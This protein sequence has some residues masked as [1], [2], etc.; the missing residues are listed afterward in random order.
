MTFLL[1]DE[2]A[3]LETLLRQ[4]VTERANLA[5]T[6]TAMTS[7]PGHDE[8]TWRRL[9]GELGLAALGVPEG[10]Q[11]P[12]L[13]PE[14][15]QVQ[16]W[17]GSQLYGGPYLASAVLATQALLLSDDAKARRH[18]PALAS[19][20]RIGALAVADE[21]GRWRADGV[22]ATADGDA[23][24]LDGVRSF[25][26]S[27]DVAHLLIVAGTTPHGPA[28]F[29]VTDLD[30]GVERS[31]LSALDP[32]RRLARLELTAARAEL[33]AEGERATHALRRL[34]DIGAIAL[35]A[36]QIGAARACLEMTVQHV[37][38]RTQFGRP[39]GSFQAVQFACADMFGLVVDG[40][41]LVRN[42]A[43]ALA[44]PDADT[45][46]AASLAKAFCSD[47]F[48]HVARQTIQLHGG[49]GFT[50]EHD[51]HLYLRRA[52]TSAAL[53]GDADEHRERLAVLL[54]L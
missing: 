5:G 23:W 17:L 43:Q 38:T 48:V 42:A 6:R 41:T 13:W 15:L 40:T 36:E 54:D 27:G 8:D 21:D 37:T 24:R 50:A 18:L 47:A 7:D 45:R 33:L 39:I 46:E 25:V 29:L 31:T 20:G 9:T 53:F 49:I 4:F 32:T 34:E 44:R 51:A 14:L 30:D 1:T 26:V 28:L 11:A 19:G 16:E 35:A 2:Q 10:P 3:D 12:V 52:R 22:T